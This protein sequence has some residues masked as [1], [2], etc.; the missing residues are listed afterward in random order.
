MEYAFLSPELIVT[1]YCCYYPNCEKE[2]PCKYNLKRH[3]KTKHLKLQ[4][5]QCPTCKKNFANQQNLDEHQNLHTGS[6]PHVCVICEKAFRQ[7]SQL[8]LHKRVH[9]VAGFSKSEIKDQEIQR[10]FSQQKK[11]RLP[12]QKVV[13]DISQPTANSKC[14][15]PK[16]KKQKTDIQLPKLSSLSTF[17]S[18]RF[19]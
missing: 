5:F 13:I 14:R 15:L 19:N 4:K 7:A 2:Y 17:K 6:M 9:I 3:V 1:N 16:I 12:R 10:K 8:S 18:K 11:S